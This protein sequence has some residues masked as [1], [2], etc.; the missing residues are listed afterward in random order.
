M[1]CAL[2]Y[3]LPNGVTASL[4]TS[5]DGLSKK[6]CKLKIV[7]PDYE[8]GFVRPEYEPIS[9]SLLAHKAATNL[10]RKNERIFGVLAKKEIEKVAED[11]NPDIYWLH[12]VTWG[13][14]A[15]ESYMLKTEKG[16]VLSYHTVVDK[17]GE[18]YGGE[19]G[20]FLMKKRAEIVCNQMDEVIVPSDIIKQK[21][22][23]YG[24]ETPITVI[25]TGVS[26]P[27][28]SFKKKELEEG[29]NIPK[30]KKILLYI[31]RISEEKNLELL[32][33][34][35]ENFKNEDIILLFV[36]PGD[37]S[38]L[39]KQAKKRGVESKI[40]FAGALKREEAQ[41][42]YKACDVFVFPSKNETQGI[43]IEE[44]MISGIPV[45]V[46]KCL[47]EGLELPEDRVVV[48][49]EESDFYKG[50][51]YALNIKKDSEIIKEAKKFVLENSSKEEMIKKQLEVFKRI[52]NNKKV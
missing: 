21:L 49:E 11:F 43:V 26:E 7:S 46:L 28:E 2:T 14:N 42:I 18:M 40:F 38:E 25:K 12:T 30:G 48:V 50:V 33:E 22:I 29:F 13:A 35:L 19:L 6:G 45:V 34:T 23:S 4:N 36:G 27:K 39:K 24:V 31:G 8:V 32:I 37:V 20:S 47:I 9:S 15:F 44:A 5:V 1:T 10:M 17:F 51:D 3:P 16:K 52:L 41:K